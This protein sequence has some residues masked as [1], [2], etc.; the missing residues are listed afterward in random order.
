MELEAVSTTSLFGVRRPAVALSPQVSWVGNALTKRGQGR[1]T[2]KS[3]HIGLLL[4]DAATVSTPQ[5][6]NYLSRHEP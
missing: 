6:R 2:P 3:E 1:R 5:A 4:S